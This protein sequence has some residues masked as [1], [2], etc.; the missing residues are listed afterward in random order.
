[1]KFAPARIRKYMTSTKEF[2]FYEH[3][4]N[5]FLAVVIG[6]V[7]TLTFSP[8]C[9]IAAQQAAKPAVEVEVE[10]PDATWLAD[11]GQFLVKRDQV[12]ALKARTGIAEAE[13]K[14][15]ALRQQHP[16][17]AKAEADM[18]ELATALRQKFPEGKE[19][20]AGRMGFVKVAPAA[21]AK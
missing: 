15:L 6:A 4:L 7:I 11:Y 17:V 14:V 12:N 8:D 9:G 3:L 13:A 21:A 19:F 2:R 5:V 1:M 10:K 20:D 16:E 18:V